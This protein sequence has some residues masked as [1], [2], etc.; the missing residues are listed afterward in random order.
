[1]SSV[2]I[3]PVAIEAVQTGVPPMTIIPDAAASA[4]AEI[5][6]AVAAPDEITSQSSVPVSAHDAIT[7]PAHLPPEV[8]IGIAAPPVVVAPVTVAEAPTRPKVE[9]MVPKLDDLD[10]GLDLGDDDPTASTPS[11]S[12]MAGDGAVE[13]DGLDQV[14]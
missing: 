14:D 10:T 3:A 2:P 8:P 5:S 1:M 11:S 4:V 6:S 9:T 7:Q 13:G 12:E